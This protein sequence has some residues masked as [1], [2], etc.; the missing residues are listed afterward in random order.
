M[1]D[2][3]RITRFLLSRSCT[4]ASALLGVGCMVAACRLGLCHADIATDSYCDGLTGVMLSA[5]SMLMVALLLILT[6]KRFNIM[7][8]DTTLPSTLYMV[9][10]AS[11]PSLYG[12][13]G[14]GCVLVLFMLSVAYVLFCLGTDFDSLRRV[15]LLF[16]V[17]GALGLVD[18]VFLYYLPALLI[19]CIQMRIFSVRTL[20]AAL[21]GIIT[22]AWIGFGL[23]LVDPASIDMPWFGMSILELPATP[24][25]VAMLAVSGITV[26]AGVFFI[27]ANILKV[28]SY[29]MQA[30]ARNGFYSIIFL[31]T[32]LL[33]ML[34]CDNLPTYLPLLMAM[35]AYQAGHFFSTRAT[36][37]FAW[38]GIAVFIAI[39]LGTY[40]WF[41]VNNLTQIS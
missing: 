4:L 19:G 17:T 36:G 24:G 28:Y 29:N 5:V 25:I 2:G 10:A 39:Y 11:L 34:D 31:V 18:A 20:A 3:R 41:I 9:M 16:A 14:S 12:T 26:L 30:R 1:I 35:T 6:N 8:S 32:A 21:L 27:S 23:G 37:R 7:R 33:A 40:S 38:I 13:F 22:P 15:F